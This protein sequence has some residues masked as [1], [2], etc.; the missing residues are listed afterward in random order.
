[1]SHCVLAIYIKKYLKAKGELWKLKYFSMVKYNLQK[2]SKRRSVQ[3]VES[4]LCW[5]EFYFIFL[6]T[7]LEISQEKFEKTNCGCFMLVNTLEVVCSWNKCPLAWPQVG[8][9]FENAKLF[10]RW[11][12]LFIITRNLWANFS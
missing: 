6:G 5:I 2:S 7:I 3:N 1:V 10:N 8:V 4:P 12:T 11:I 9:Y